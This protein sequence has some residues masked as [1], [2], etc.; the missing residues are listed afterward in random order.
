MALENNARRQR[1]SPQTFSAA[2]SSATAE[3][4]LMLLLFLDGLFS[5]LVTKF[6]RYSKLQIPCLFCSRLDH[7]LG[8]ERPGFYKELICHAH[9]LDISSLAFCH[10][11]QKLADVRDM[12]EDCLISFATEKKSNSETYRSLVGKLERNIVHGENGHLSLPTAVDPDGLEVKFQ[13]EDVVQV[14]LLKKDNTLGS[15]K[16]RYCSCCLKVFSEKSY[17]QRLL[18]TKSIGTEFLE[19]DVGLFGQASHGCLHCGD[20]SRKKQDK[21]LGSSASFRIENHSFDPL[22][23]VGYTELK[24]NSDSESDV[25][26]SDDDDDEVASLVTNDVK[27]DHFSQ[28]VKQEPPIELE[29]RNALPKA[30]LDDMALEKQ[31]HT[32]SLPEPSCLPT[33]EQIHVVEQHDGDSSPSVPKS[34]IAH[35]LE[36]L[37]WNE[38]KAKD[39][40]SSPSKLISE[41]PSSNCEL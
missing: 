12:C 5:Y 31:I 40:P 11:H 25:M 36:E 24:V 13:R 33:V 34:T 21:P 19:L 41:K 23:H 6:A 32:T 28:S 27:E 30:L 39:P 16:T 18:Q 1:V 10:I 38:F 4:L 14:P 15:P 8:R 35:G 2:L 20:V 37:S 7:I 3:W 17:E 26:L 22:S 9:K 29:N